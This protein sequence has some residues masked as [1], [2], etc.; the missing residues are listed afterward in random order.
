MTMTIAAPAAPTEIPLEH[1][2]ANASLALL[3]ED[4]AHIAEFVL[5][6]DGHAIIDGQSF[7][8]KKQIRVAERR[9]GLAKLRAGKI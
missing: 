2:P 7:I 8:I 9:A 4:D 5:T 3:L 1:W 6:N